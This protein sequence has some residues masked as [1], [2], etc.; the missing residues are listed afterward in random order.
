MLDI[1]LSLDRKG[2]GVV[3]FEI[4]EELYAVPSREARCQTLS[5]FIDAPH[6]IVR[7]A[8]VKRSAWLACKDIDPETIHWR[9]FMDCRVKPGN[10]A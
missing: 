9:R 5:M 8:D 1:L 10:D 7:H 3:S 6:Q 2:S 4:D